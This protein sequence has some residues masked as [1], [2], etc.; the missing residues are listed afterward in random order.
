MTKK[1]LNQR[2]DVKQVILYLD[3][4]YGISMIFHILNGREIYF[5]HINIQSEYV[6]TT[7]AKGHDQ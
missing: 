5:G 2:S 7:V 6:G 1:E 4:D 3:S